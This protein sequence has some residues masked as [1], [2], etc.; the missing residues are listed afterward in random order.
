MKDEY[1]GN[2]ELDSEGDDTTAIDILKSL[3]DSD[4]DLELKTQVIVPKD[5]AGL[6]VLV[7]VLKMYDLRGSAKLLE[8]FIIYYFGRTQL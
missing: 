6:Q 3:L 4:T 5:V 8:T 7:S 1:K 2:E